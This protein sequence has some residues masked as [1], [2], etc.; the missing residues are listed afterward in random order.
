MNDHL[1]P[2]RIL[3]VTLAVAVVGVGDVVVVEA[4]ND[5]TK[6]LDRFTYEDET[7]DRGDGF[8]DYRPPDWNDI[9]CDERTREGLD[10]CVGY[11]YKWHEGIDWTIQKNYCRWCPEGSF[12]T[13]HGGVDENGQEIRHHQSP[14]D[15]QRE[16]GLEL[17]THENARECVDCT[18]TFI[19]IGFLVLS[20]RYYSS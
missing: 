6:F 3:V 13:C 4:Q 9:K 12:G 14:I 7:I 18:S 2:V 17:G 19:V 10:Q 20:L 15:L 1:S 5:G 8:F 11:S 16:Y